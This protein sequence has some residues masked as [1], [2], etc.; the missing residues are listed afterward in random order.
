MTD[1][2][3]DKIRQQNDL[4]RRQLFAP[5]W[6]RSIPCSVCHTQGIEGFSDD[7]RDQIYVTVR[8][9]DDFTEDNDPHGEHDFGAFD[10]K[11]Q[12]IFWK[13]DYYAHDLQHGSEDPSDTKQTM[14]VLTIL[15]ASEY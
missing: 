10:F 12:K 13:I 11:G 15:L 2:K 6:A 1:D 3:T 7:E 8:D 4:T 14:R 9:F 5:H